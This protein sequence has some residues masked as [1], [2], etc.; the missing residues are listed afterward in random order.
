MATAA[1]P[2][3]VVAAADASATPTA[4]AAPS[5]PKRIMF[6]ALAGLVLGGAVGGFV[7]APRL[8]HTGGDAAVEA[9]HEAVVPAGPAFVHQVENLVLNPAN[10]N[11][12]RFLLV[13]TTIVAKDAAAVEELAGRDAEVRDRIVDLLSSR[14]IEQL[15]DPAQRERLKTDLAAAIGT[16]FETGIVQR[17][18]LPQF[19]LQ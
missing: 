18:L 4:S 2:T 12:S 14:T 16:L 8:S 7:I 11:G 19:V 17:V 1:A 10:T 9:S 6:G 13:T 15:G 3:Q 5:G